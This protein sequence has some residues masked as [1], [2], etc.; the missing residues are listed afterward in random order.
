MENVIFKQKWRELKINPNYWQ[1][2]SHSYSK[3]SKC[4][5]SESFA[6]IAANIIIISLG[7]NKPSRRRGLKLN[8][9]EFAV[10][11]ESP[12]KKEFQHFRSHQLKLRFTN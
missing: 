9:S 5:P 1:N 6:N 3:R 4:L 10:K 7:S 2:N 11:Y 12:Y 8:Y